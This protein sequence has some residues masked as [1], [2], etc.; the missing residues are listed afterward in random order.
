MRALSKHSWQ[1]RPTL[2][3]DSS[4]PM[5][6]DLKA[7]GMVLLGVALPLQESM[8]HDGWIGWIHNGS[9]DGDGWLLGGSLAARFS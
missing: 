2:P 3:C 4:M 7:Q 9:G 5:W 8:S 1:S 6:S